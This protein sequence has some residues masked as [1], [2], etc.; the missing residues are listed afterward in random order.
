[1]RKMCMF[2]MW[3]SWED[4]R[5]KIQRQ[6]SVLERTALRIRNRLMYGAWKAWENTKTGFATNKW[7]KLHNIS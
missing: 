5:K 4:S 2:K 7:E 3:G 6:R 1:M